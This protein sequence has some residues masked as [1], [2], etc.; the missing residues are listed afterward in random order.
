MPLSVVYQPRA[1]GL[2]LSQRLAAGRPLRRPRLIQQ[3]PELSITRP[4]HWDL[5]AM[6]SCFQA[7]SL[8]VPARSV[9]Q[10]SVPGPSICTFTTW[11]AD[12]PISD[13]VCIEVDVSTQA[14]DLRSM[15]DML[16]ER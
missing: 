15:Q 4:C 2:T 5:I 1:S 6:T 3:V 13:L 12:E 16:S 7:D 8:M 14:T 11:C 10:N 9:T